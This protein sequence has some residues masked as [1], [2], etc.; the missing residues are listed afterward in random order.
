[1]QQKVRV[2]SGV[3][4]GGWSNMLSSCAVIPIRMSWAFLDG[5]SLCDGSSSICG[6]P[7]PADI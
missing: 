7:A 3:G 5:A 2:A 6:A 1:M 4:W